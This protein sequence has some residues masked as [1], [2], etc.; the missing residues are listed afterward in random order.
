MTRV[1][2]GVLEAPNV[3]RLDEPV[4]L[5]LHVPVDVTITQPPTDTDRP[6]STFLTMA[7]SLTV[8]GPADFS[9]RWE[10]YVADDDR[11]RNR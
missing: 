10:E 7:G 3:L 11:D 6:A 8:D 1:V 9:E 2:R 5:P 4:E